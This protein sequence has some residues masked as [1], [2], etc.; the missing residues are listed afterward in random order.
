[1]KTV[2]W[3][4]RSILERGF[5]PHLLPLVQITGGSVVR[6]L[7]GLPLGSDVDLIVHPAIADA[8]T[9]VLERNRWKHVGE[10][11]GDH[12]SPVDD[13][14][15]SDRYVYEGPSGLKVDLL[16]TDRPSD[17]LSGFD[18]AECACTVSH[19]MS[20]PTE[21]IFRGFAPI[22]R[23]LHARR[24]LCER[25]AKKW[26]DLGFEVVERFERCPDDAP[27]FFMA[28]ASGHDSWSEFV[29]AFPGW[30]TAMGWSDR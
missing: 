21:P 20:D 9:D 27:W 1:M 15:V 29:R 4:V 25:R 2:D 6:A 28:G 22:G 10:E 3:L 30:R 18:I 8:V 7:S 5:P 24:S 11:S 23:T 14:L 17:L 16:V 13:R 26:I 12:E 19:T